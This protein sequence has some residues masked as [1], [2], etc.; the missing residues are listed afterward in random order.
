MAATKARVMGISAGV[1]V[2]LT[3]GL[4]VA[5]F[6]IPGLFRWLAGIPDEVVYRSRPH[7]TVISPRPDGTPGEEE[8]EWGL[9]IEHRAK[10]SRDGE[11]AEVELTV[12][13]LTEE[14]LFACRLTYDNDNSG[15]GELGVAEMN[16]IAD[17]ATFENGKI[18]F[19][20]EP[21]GSDHAKRDLP[22]TVRV[23]PGAA[24]NPPARTPPAGALPVARLKGRIPV[25][26]SRA[27]F[28]AISRTLGRYVSEIRLAE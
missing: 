21:P 3:A 24:L 13:G 12:I 22:R 18:A 27:A 5:A 4:A 8:L 23:R 14:A 9:D 28:T 6:Q 7:Q 20:F 15:N 16:Q 17:I 11:F 19:E 1:A 2:G 10:I 26:A 25:T